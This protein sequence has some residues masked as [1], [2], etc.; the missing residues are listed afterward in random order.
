MGRGNKNN[1]HNLVI[2]F[3]YILK[4]AR[5]GGVHSPAARAGGL[6]PNNLNIS[7]P[8]LGSLKINKEVKV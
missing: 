2:K 6:N 4:A 1:K 7:I 5:A 8:S 3:K